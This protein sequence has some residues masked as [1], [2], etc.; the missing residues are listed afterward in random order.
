MLCPLLKILKLVELLLKILK[1]KFKLKEEPAD[2][3]DKRI[4]LVTNEII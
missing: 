3:L 1:R 2:V 4:V